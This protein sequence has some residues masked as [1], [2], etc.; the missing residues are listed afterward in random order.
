LFFLPL[1]FV[2]TAQLPGHPANG[3]VEA[4]RQA[5]A[6]DLSFPLDVSVTPTG[7]VRAG[8][9]VAARVEVVSRRLFDDVRIRVVPSAGVSVL[10][11]PAAELGL[12]R[13]GEARETT[14]TVLPAGGA[15]RRTVEVVVD[16][17]DDGQRLTTGAVLNLVFE[18]EPWRT[19]ED[20]DGTPVIEVPARRIR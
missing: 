18:E 13:A 15:A 4:H 10:A 8:T 20:A 7:A 2:G 1:L 3:T 16:A 5:C 11:T 12:I 19:V 17:Y 14:F 9:P 6:A